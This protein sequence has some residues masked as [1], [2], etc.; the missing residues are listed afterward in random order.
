MWG[1][2]VSRTSIPSCW[3]LCCCLVAHLRQPILLT[4]PGGPVLLGTTQPPWRQWRERSAGVCALL[5][6]RDATP[7]WCIRVPEWPRLHIRDLPLW[8]HDRI[9][10][11]LRG[12]K[13]EEWEDIE[14]RVDPCLR[15]PHGGHVRSSSTEEFASPIVERK[16]DHAG[17]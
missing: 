7:I 11:E 10:R 3:S 12:R 13:W 16:F 6:S 5:K 9:E 4:L 8:N 2:P 17:V 14:R 15:W 1:Q